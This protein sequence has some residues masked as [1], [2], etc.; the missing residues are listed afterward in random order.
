M[1]TRF[2][3]TIYTTDD[4]NKNN[5][6]K[7]DASDDTLIPEGSLIEEVSMLQLRRF[8]LSYWNVYHIEWFRNIV[9]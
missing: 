3:N 5:N 1:S 6:M 8:I 4:D 9:L 7:Y 2:S